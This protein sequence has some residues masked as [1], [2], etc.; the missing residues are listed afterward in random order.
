MFARHLHVAH[1]F[2]CISDDVSGIDPAIRIIPLWDDLAKTGNPHGSREPSC[3]RRMK[4]FSGQMREFVGDRVAWCDLDMVLTGDVTPIFSRKESVVLLPTDVQNIP[5]NG[6]LV[7]VTPGAHEE[8]WTGFD[9]ATS[10]QLA[11]KSGCYGSDQGWMAYCLRKKA[12]FWKSGPGGDGIYFFGQHMRRIG[13]GQKL[14]DDA[15]IVS[16]HG[17]GNPWEEPYRQ[18]AWVQKHYV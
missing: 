3:Y 4:L 12:A 8:V 11:R 15:R 7:L 1:E 18:F 9:P 5:V 6:S 13:Q 10:P 14:P 16:F 17:R 2:V